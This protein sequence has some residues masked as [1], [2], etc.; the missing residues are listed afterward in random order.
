MAEKSMVK[1]AFN[2]TF[3]T[4]AS[5]LIG[6]LYVFL[7]SRFVSPEGLA[8]YSYAYIPYAIFLDLATLGIPT[9]ITRLIAEQKEEEKI[10]FSR[11]LY[12]RIRG[13]SFMLG[14]LMFLTLFLLSTPLAYLIIGGRETVTNRLAD[15]SFVIRLISLALLIIPNL[16][17]IR[18]IF[19]GLKQTQITARS[20]VIEQMIRVSMI[21]VSAY[22]IIRVFHQKYPLAIYLAVLAASISGFVTYLIMYVKYKRLQDQDVSRDFS[23]STRQLIRHVFSYALPAVFITLLFGLFSLTDTLTFNGA[24]ALGGHP[25]SEIQYAT[26]VFE[27][28]KLINLP[29]AFGISLGTAFMVYIKDQQDVRMIEKQLKR[30]LE[31]L[32]FIFMPLLLMM[33]VFADDIYNILFASTSYGPNILLSSA[34][35]MLPIGILHVLSGIMQRLNFEWVFIRRLLI[36]I[37]LKLSLNVPLIVY[38]GTDGAILSSFVGWMVPVLLNLRFIFRRLQVNRRFSIRRFVTIT[39]I[40]GLAALIVSLIDRIIPLPT[41]HRWWLFLKFGGMSSLYLILYLGG[42]YAFGII[43]CIFGR[44]LNIREFIV[45]KRYSKGN[46][47]VIMKENER[48]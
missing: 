4:L 23:L 29:L 36:G 20:Q 41:T 34:P 35:L 31:I 40:G 25:H 43:D 38:F 8:L 5:R 37:V 1:S 17:L 45:E 28:Q 48:I 18:G 44:S 16:S 27:V 26:Y 15:V 46:E 32:F 47:C 19:N 24:F 33:M 39:L 21:L 6:I 13:V 14:L 2:L 3:G 11:H 12:N 30:S 22:L 10:E 9:G 42:C 7:F